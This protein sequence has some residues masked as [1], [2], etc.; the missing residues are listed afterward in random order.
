MRPGQDSL[1]RFRPEEKAPNH[2][3]MVMAYDCMSM[4]YWHG[5]VTAP[6]VT[7]DSREASAPTT[8]VSSVIITQHVGE[9]HQRQI[10]PVAQRRQVLSRGNAFPAATNTNSHGFHGAAPTN[11]VTVCSSPWP[12][13]SV[14]A[15]LL[16]HRLPSSGLSGAS[17]A[18]PDA[19][20]DIVSMTSTDDSSQYAQIL[21]RLSPATRL[22]VAQRLR[23][24]AWELAAAGIRMREPDLPADA[25]EERVRTVFTRAST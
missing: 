10:G 24:T 3:C 9:L 20:T 7:P 16:C 19:R 25:V 6:R 2:R 4:T 5:A 13:V 23:D 22:A 15:I 18:H 8:L 14:A 12:F 17:V 11:S 1:S 21:K